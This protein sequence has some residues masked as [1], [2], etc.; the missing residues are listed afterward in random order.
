MG[1]VAQRMIGRF[2]AAIAITIVLSSCDTPGVSR[3]KTDLLTDVPAAKVI[4]IDVVEGNDD[5]IYYEISFER[6]PGSNV[7]KVIW[8]YTREGTSKNWRLTSK[9]V[10]PEGP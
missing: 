3:V 5:A 2:G 6:Q 10:P 4:S 9:N 8:L 7:E 1:Q